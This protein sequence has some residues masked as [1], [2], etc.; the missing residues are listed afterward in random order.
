M[1][2]HNRFGDKILVT[3]RIPYNSGISRVQVNGETYNSFGDEVTLE[4]KKRLNKWQSVKQKIKKKER[5]IKDDMA[6]MWLNWSI[7]LHFNFQ[8]YIYI[9]I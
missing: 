7:V 3:I 2:R 8:I 4:F 1:E 9:Y 5:K 6:L